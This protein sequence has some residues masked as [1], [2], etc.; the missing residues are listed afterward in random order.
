[1]IRIA[2]I[3]DLDVAVSLGMK[4]A[5]ASPYVDYI[6]EP[7]VRAVLQEVIEGPQENGIV[8]LC[9]DYAMIFGVARKFIYG[10][11]TGATE[12]A[13]WVN[14]DQRG[15]SVGKELFEAFEYWA[16]RVGCLTITMTSLDDQVG[17]YYEKKGYRLLE[18]AYVKQI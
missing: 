10:P 7:S 2:T 5:Q 18:R 14:E 17:S 1:M 4:F 15:T 12:L 8:L 6:D 13:W 3:E 9:E 11:I 16:K